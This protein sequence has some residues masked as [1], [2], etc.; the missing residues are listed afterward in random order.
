MAYSLTFIFSKLQY[1]RNPD[2]T[3]DMLLLVRSIWATLMVML[4]INT[5]AK[6]ILYEEVDRENI[7]PLAFRSV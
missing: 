3:P 1:D 7:A 5:G 2:L 6:R 4:I